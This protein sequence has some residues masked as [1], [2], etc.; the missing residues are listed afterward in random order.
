MNRDAEIRELAYRLWDEAGRPD[1]RDQDFWLQ[2][3]A[4]LT[5]APSP[6]AAKA[7]A[8]AVKPAAKKAPAK[9]K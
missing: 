6:K 2:A 3:E 7:K 5:K 9:A 8:E 1:S 4:C